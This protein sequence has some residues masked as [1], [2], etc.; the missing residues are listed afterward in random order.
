MP[1]DDLSIDA[2]DIEKYGEIS[3]SLAHYYA[4][5]VRTVA[6]GD[7]TLERGVRE[8]VGQKLVV[9]GIRSQV[10]QEAG[11]SAG[12]DNRVVCNCST[13]FSCAASSGPAGPGSS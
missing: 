1:D 6:G 9:A 4:D 11:R 12:L 7:R 3:K 5:A 8:W 2:E 13:A 10:R